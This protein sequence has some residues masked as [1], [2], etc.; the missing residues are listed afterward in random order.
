MTVYADEPT[1]RLHLIV[2]G[3][4]QG[5]GFRA[6]TVSTARRLGLTGWVKNSS[7][8]RSVEIIAVGR[9]DVLR[10]LINAVQIG[11]PASNVTRVERS[12]LLSHEVFDSFSVRY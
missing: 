9:D 12:K 5:V 11:P 8:G 4:V 10:E 3:R 1:T 7:D 6:F 2:H